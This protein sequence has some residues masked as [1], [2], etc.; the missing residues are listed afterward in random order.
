LLAVAYAVVAIRPDIAPEPTPPPVAETV[1]AAP[2]PAVAT[3]P[4][5]APPSAPDPRAREALTGAHTLYFERKRVQAARGYARALEL[6][7]QLRH[8]SGLAANLVGT[9]GYAG[10]LPAETIRKYPSPEFVFELGRR[11]SQPGRIGSQRAVALLTELGHAG[12]IDQRGVAL[13]ELAEA[14]TC[15]ER[16]VAVKRLRALREPR[17][18]PLLRDSVKR[19]W[20]SQDKNS[21]LREEAYKAIAEL[22][23]LVPSTAAA[24]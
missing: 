1:V 5:P 17:A 7:S 9:L 3:A 12:R 16:L 21:C 23:E 4:D 24:R 18:L 19:V 15:E 8:D 20:F 22:Q 10:E 11:T 6:D 2:A 14:P 13:T